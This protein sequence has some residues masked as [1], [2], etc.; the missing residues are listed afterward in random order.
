MGLE[1][2]ITSVGTEQSVV[3][4][5]VSPCFCLLTAHVTYCSFLKQKHSTCF[6]FPPELSGKALTDLLPFVKLYPLRPTADTPVEI[7]SR[8]PS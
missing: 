4:S 8:G 7:F 3:V 6:T 1:D 2:L 5:G